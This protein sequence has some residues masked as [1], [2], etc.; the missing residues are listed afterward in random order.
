MKVFLIKSTV[1]NYVTFQTVGNCDSSDSK[2]FK[3]TCVVVDRDRQYEAQISA[4]F[5]EIQIY[6]KIDIFIKE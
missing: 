4:Q 3:Y 6:M 2:R 1:H 5:K